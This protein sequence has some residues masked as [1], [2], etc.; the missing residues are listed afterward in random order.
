MINW[1]ADVQDDIINILFHFLVKY[2]YNK[3]IDS[4][5]NTKCGK[6][7]CEKT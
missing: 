6:N 3:I 2:M 5:E 1:W 4:K 7:I